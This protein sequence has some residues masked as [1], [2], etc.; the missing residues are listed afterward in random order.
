LRR[1]LSTGP[2]VGRNGQIGDVL[3]LTAGR[4]KGSNVTLDFDLD[5]TK[6]SFMGGDGPLL[7]AACAS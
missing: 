3:T 6:G 2:F 5:A 7:F 1:A 4:T